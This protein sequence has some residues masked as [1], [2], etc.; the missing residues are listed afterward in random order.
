MMVNTPSISHAEWSQA[1]EEA[2]TNTGDEGATAAEL[3]AVLKVGV[4]SMH[5][6]LQALARAGRLVV[7]R[8]RRHAISGNQVF[9]PVYRIRPAPPVDA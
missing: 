7:G 2:L 6:S 3:R 9:V 1:L 5:L 8:A 4:H